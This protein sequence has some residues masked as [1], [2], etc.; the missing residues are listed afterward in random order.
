MKRILSLILICIIFSAVMCSCSG[1]I[2]G[3]DLTAKVSADESSTYNFKNAETSTP[4]SYASYKNSAVNFSFKM[5]SSIYSNKN[6]TVYSPSALYYQLSLLQNATSSDTQKQIKL[7]TGKNIALDDLNS[8]NGYFFSRLENLSNPEKKRYIDINGDIF[9]N[10]NMPVSQI[11]LQKNAN[12]YNQN[13][14]RLSYTSD[15]FTEKVNSYISEKTENKVK[16]TDTPEK[17]TNL[18]LLNSAFMKDSWLD[19][20]KRDNISTDTFSGIDGDVEAEFMKST[21]YYIADKG[22]TGFVKDFKNTPAKFVALLPKENNVYK[23]INSLNS[24]RYFELMDSINV[25]KTCDAYLPQFSANS[26]L[27]FKDNSNLEFLTKQGNYSALS[28]NKTAKIS[29]IIQSLEFK[30]TDSGISTNKL[31]SSNSTKKEP[32]KRVQLNRPF[33]FMI[34][35]NESYIPI[36]MGVISV[37]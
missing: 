6:N 12:F 13:I 21:E 9:F 27:N 23:F 1:N 20:Y 16:F 26:T 37:I 8:C 29:D 22:C 5:L 4:S 36:Y 18:L 25:F 2:P 17:T 15:N 31:I 19:G 33:L 10:E 34:V 3:E 35:D 24:D 11:F 7:L 30:I 32:D 14:F 28:Y